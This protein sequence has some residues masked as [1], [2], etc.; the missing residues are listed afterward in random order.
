ML[1]SHIKY[2]K[3]SFIKDVIKAPRVT[4]TAIPLFHLPINTGHDSEGRQI[5]WFRLFAQK[6]NPVSNYRVW[7]HVHLSFVIADDYGDVLHH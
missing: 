4:Y 5:N 6:K 2:N 3:Y 1:S 7:S